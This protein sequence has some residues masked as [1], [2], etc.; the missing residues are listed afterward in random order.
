MKDLIL[1]SEYRTLEFLLWYISNYPSQS[2][3]AFYEEVS[4]MYQ[5][6]DMRCMSLYST[7]NSYDPKSVD[8]KRYWY[9]ELYG[10]GSHFFM[11]QAKKETDLDSLKNE[12]KVISFFQKQEKHLIFTPKP[13]KYF[14]EFGILVTE[15]IK[16]EPF[17]KY[18]GL[19]S[20]L[21]DKTLNKCVET[22]EQLGNTLREM[23]DYISLMGDV[24]LQKIFPSNIPEISNIQVAQ[25]D[26]TQISYSNLA[27]LN[28]TLKE[29]V[30]LLNPEI[31]SYVIE[32]NKNWQISSFIH[33]D[34]KFRNMFYVNNYFKFI[35]WEHSGLGDKV[36]DIVNILNSI[37]DCFCL[38]SERFASSI[39]KSDDEYIRT[40]SVIAAF[41]KG[42]FKDGELRNEIRK[43]KLFWLMYYLEL[44][45]QEPTTIN[46]IMNNINFFVEEYDES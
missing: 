34:L 42:Y 13:Y 10:N 15:Y 9:M 20:P 17:S 41:F 38:K 5:S 11:K 39:V 26:Q 22:F 3:E 46:T 18:V 30:N 31:L 44:I 12:L 33:F 37:T 28:Y 40:K 29:F 36:W 7:A 23:H 32:F 8:Y 43:V 1:N 19:Y 21:T 6:K 27:D 25:K 2:S 35:D 24:K 14:K 16:E 4:N 45:V